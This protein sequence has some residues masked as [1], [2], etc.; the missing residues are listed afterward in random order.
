MPVL[1]GGIYVVD[2]DVYA[3]VDGKLTYGLE[4][5]D[6]VYAL[7]LNWVAYVPDPVPESVGN[8][9]DVVPGAGGYVYVVVVLELVGLY[10]IFL[11]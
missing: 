4:V 2:V 8:P 11:Y 5:D 10:A 7:E 1:G 9:V 3:L 6:G